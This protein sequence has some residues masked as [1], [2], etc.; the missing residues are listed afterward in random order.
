[1][2]NFLEHYFQCIAKCQ[3]FCG[4]KQQKKKIF[5]INIIHL[6]GN[7]E[8]VARVIIIK[9]TFSILKEVHCRGIQRAPG[10]YAFIFSA[11]FLS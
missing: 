3:Q 5:L 8:S 4:S 2:E 11:L 1:M 9:N 10:I 7:S 6:P